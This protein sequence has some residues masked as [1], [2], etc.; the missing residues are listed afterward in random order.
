MKKRNVDDDKTRQ[1]PKLMGRVTDSNTDGET[2]PKLNLPT[3][4]Q[5]P[6]QN[7]QSEKQKAKGKLMIRDEELEAVENRE[8]YLIPLMTRITLMQEEAYEDEKKESPELTPLTMPPRDILAEILEEKEAS[9]GWGNFDLEL[10]QRIRKIEETASGDKSSILYRFEVKI[11]NSDETYSAE[12]PAKDVE[13]V[14]WIVDKTGGA[15]WFS[16][17]KRAKSAVEKVIHGQIK[18]YTGVE[19]LKYPRNGWKKLR[20]GWFYLTDFGFIGLLQTQAQGDTDQKFLYAS[21]HAGKKQTFLE[22]LEMTTI[23]QNSS[24]AMFLFLFTHLSMMAALFEEA[25]AP[26]KFITAVI[27]PTNSRKTSMAL[28]LSK[29]FNRDQIHTPELSFES[30]MGGIEVMCSQCQDTP[31]IIDDFHPALTRKKQNELNEKLEFVLRRYGDRVAKKRMTDF[32]P[33]KKAG[34]YPVRGGCIITGEDITGVESSLARTIVLRVEK[35]TVDNRRL[36][37]YQDHPLILSSHLYDFIK[38]ITDEQERIIPLIEENFKTKRSNHTYFYPRYSEVYA[39][40]G[41]TAELIAEYAVARGFSTPQEMQEWVNFV[42]ISVDQIIH[43]NVQ[44]NFAENEAITILTALREMVSTYPAINVSDAEKTKQNAVYMDDKY[45]Y[46]RAQMLLEI[47]NKY[48]ARLGMRSPELN[49][50]RLANILEDK[51]VLYVYEGK[52]ETRKTHMLPGKSLDK[53]R[54]MFIRRKEMEIL[55]ENSERI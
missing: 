52:N 42:E 30:T 36:A 45:Y 7:E 25:G 24:T 3:S 21:H 22:A 46:V 37:F 38:Y 20:N 31:V 49:S 39:Q 13:K 5:T 50:K 10:L 34:Y 4:S 28:C 33:N 48:C 35:N 26:I 14:S 9:E 54:Y 12:I 32:S 47:V 19:K 29:V 17:D 15:A 44:N 1:L 11:R 27:G 6:E 18:A 51:G 8:D 2:Q 43:Q 55:I 53:R 40:M 16:R 23:T 41:I